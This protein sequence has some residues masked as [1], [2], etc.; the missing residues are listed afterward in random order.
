MLRRLADAFTDLFRPWHD[1]GLPEELAFGEIEARQELR[2]TTG[3][4]W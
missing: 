2:V 3:T 1:D 4:G